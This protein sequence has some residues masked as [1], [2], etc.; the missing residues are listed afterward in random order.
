MRWK[1]PQQYEH[2]GRPSLSLRRRTRLSHRGHR[3]KLQD[4]PFGKHR[5]ASRTSRLS[6]IAPKPSQTLVVSTVTLP[7]AR[8]R[9]TF[10]EAGR[11]SSNNL[12]VMTLRYH[13]VNERGNNGTRLR[14]VTLVT[15]L[16]HR[17]LAQRLR[18]VHG[19]DFESPQRIV[20]THRRAQSECPRRADSSRS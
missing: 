14:P 7:S 17:T 12:C 15:R 10:G 2:I 6:S 8:R 19:R 18:R 3:K 11:D 5:C 16:C 13:A 20:G 1:L 9:E 4:P